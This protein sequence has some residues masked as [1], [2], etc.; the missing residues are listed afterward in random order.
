MQFGSIPSLIAAA[1]ALHEF[2]LIPSEVINGNETATIQVEDP[3]GGRKG[4]GPTSAPDVTTTALPAIGG[5][6][7][8]LTMAIHGVTG[9]VIAIASVAILAEVTIILGRICN[10]TLINLRIK[11]FLIFVSLLKRQYQTS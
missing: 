7:S 8:D 3:R 11:F 6:T 5:I 4:P 1:I 9:F 2:N 10:I